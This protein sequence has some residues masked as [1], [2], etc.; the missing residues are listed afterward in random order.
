MKNAA[1]PS[2][3]RRRLLTALLGASLLGGHAAGIANPAVHAPAPAPAPVPAKRRHALVIGNARYAVAANVLINPVNDARLIAGSLRKRD[4]DV[5]LL[6]DQTTAQMESAVD[7]FAA[8][9][10]SSDLALVYFAGHAVAVD[11]VNYL[12]GVELAVPLADVGIRIAQQSSL[13]LARVS[14]A[15][16]RAQ[17]RA[18]LLVLDACRTNLTRGA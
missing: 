8:R 10:A 6:T 2:G 7:E 14:Q 13:S 18:R 4:F 1:K 5:T 12:F 17:V 16:R 3:N 9:A 15:L 11:D